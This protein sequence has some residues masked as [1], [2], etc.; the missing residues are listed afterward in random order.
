MHVSSRGSGTTPCDAKCMEERERGE[1]ERR[2]EREQ[3]CF[4][5]LVFVLCSVFYII[6]RKA[7]RTA[8][9]SYCY[10]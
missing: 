5:S 9:K 3:G 7:G 2:G 10:M 6:A 8:S 4:S 1:E